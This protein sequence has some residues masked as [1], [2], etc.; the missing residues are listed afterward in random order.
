MHK[1]EQF[2]LHRRVNLSKRRL[3]FIVVKSCKSA[4]RHEKENL[5]LK[6]WLAVGVRLKSFRLRQE[7]TQKLYITSLSIERDTQ[8]SEPFC[9]KSPLSGGL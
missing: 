9:R 3:H 4:G 7:Q 2:V 5:Q 6:A 1:D 8:Y